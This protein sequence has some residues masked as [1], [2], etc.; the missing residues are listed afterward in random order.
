MLYEKCWVK[1]SEYSRNK[2]FEKF[3]ARVSRIDRVGNEEVRKEV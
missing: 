1:E 3:G 2:V